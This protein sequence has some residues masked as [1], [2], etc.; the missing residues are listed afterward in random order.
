VFHAEEPIT[1]VEQHSFTNT[2]RFRPPQLVSPGYIRHSK[3]F[4]SQGWHIGASGPWFPES[5]FSYLQIDD[6]ITCY[7][8]LS[9]P[10]KQT[11]SS[12]DWFFCRGPE[13]DGSY[14]G[15]LSRR[16]S[17]CSARSITSKLHS[18]ATNYQTNNSKW[19]PSHPSSLRLLLPPVSSPLPP[20]TWPP[21]HLVT[22]LPARA[23]P[24]RPAPTTVATTPGGPMVAPRSPTPTATPDPTA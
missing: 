15:S 5:Q 9:N 13:D 14:K 11:R 17:S 18:L 24:P 1:H 7:H 21:V 20:L 4:W 19:S 16:S 23:L 6:R 8:A 10:C 3:Y 2:P 12:E 22:L